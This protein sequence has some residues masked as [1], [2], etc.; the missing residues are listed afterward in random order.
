MTRTGQG[1]LTTCPVEVCIN[2]RHK[3]GEIYLLSVTMARGWG[4]RL[5]RGLLPTAA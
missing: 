5:E 2:Y 1:S 3:I 4:G